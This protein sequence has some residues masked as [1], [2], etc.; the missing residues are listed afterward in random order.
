MSDWLAKGGWTFTPEEVAGRITR[1]E[2]GY[3]APLDILSTTDPLFVKSFARAPTRLVLQAGSRK[4]AS[5]GQGNVHSPDDNGALKLGFVAV[6]TRMDDGGYIVQAVMPPQQ[7]CDV[8][9]GKRVFG[10]GFLD[11]ELKRMTMD[12]LNKVRHTAAP[13]ATC[14]RPTTD[15]C[16]SPLLPARRHLRHRQATWRVRTGFSS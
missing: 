6:A 7:D 14:H 1:D 4:L 10:G 9:L 15:A 12:A 11:S 3:V 2:E 8:N 16:R 13:P 5:G